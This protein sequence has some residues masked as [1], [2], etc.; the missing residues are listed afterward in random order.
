[1]TELTTTQQ[2]QAVHIAR[3]CHEANRALCLALGDESQPHWEVAPDW[4]R[5]SAIA[6]VNAHL[7]RPRSPEESH[8]LWLEHKQA[9]GWVYGPTK[10][11]EAKTHPCIRPYAELPLD[12]RRKDFLFA[13][14]VFALQES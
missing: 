3:I 13:A 2:M 4:Q 7:E 1:M 12:Q 10:D 6:G 8:Q 14:I 5:D 11:P 9:A